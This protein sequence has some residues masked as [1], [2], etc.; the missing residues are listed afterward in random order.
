MTEV[1][2]VGSKFSVALPP[3][4]YAKFLKEGGIKMDNTMLRTNLQ[5]RMND[6]EE[7]ERIHSLIVK[8]ANPE[9]GTRRSFVK[10]TGVKF[11][12]EEFCKESCLTEYREI[13]A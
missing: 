6:Q 7:T 4:G 5:G 13:N 1:Q 2:W 3:Q 11:N 8:C 9:C 12:G 10:G